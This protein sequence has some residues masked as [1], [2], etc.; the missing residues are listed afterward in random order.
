MSANPITVTN[1]RNDALTF[2]LNTHAFEAIRCLIDGDSDTALQMMSEI[3][4]MAD[5]MADYILHLK[6]NLS[7]VKDLARLLLEER[8]KAL[9][10]LGNKGLELH[11]VRQE[12][13]NLEAAA[14]FRGYHE[15]ID[16]IRDLMA[17]RDMDTSIL[18]VLGRG[19]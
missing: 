8:D 11:Q 18:D 10:A 1:E 13:P 4:W 2:G 14:H 6:D 7:D 3:S 12:I 16:S 9:D 17:D 5:Q 19:E 15:A